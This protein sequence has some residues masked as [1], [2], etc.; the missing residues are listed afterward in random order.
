MNIDLLMDVEM[1]LVIRVGST[2]LLLREVAALSAGSVVE[3]PRAAEDPVDILIN[4]RI[5]A[6]G[7]LVLVNG[8]YGLRITEVR[9]ENG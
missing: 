3:L 8:N 9:R 5:V 1:P 4:G 7:L 6:R 2:N